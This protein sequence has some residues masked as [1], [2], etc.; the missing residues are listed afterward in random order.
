MLASA[1]LSVLPVAFMSVSPEA[2]FF[3]VHS[4]LRP[5]MCQVHWDM[6]VASVSVEAL[7]SLAAAHM[8]ARQPPQHT[9]A[10]VL[11]LVLRRVGLP[12]D[13]LGMR[14]AG[15]RAAPH[16][17][18]QGEGCPAPVPPPLGGAHILGFH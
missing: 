4:A 16:H 11:R 13:R 8:C 3:L 10:P 15:V 9:S 18:R 17:P 14:R 2:P 5:C 6:D 7:N 12:S 1:T